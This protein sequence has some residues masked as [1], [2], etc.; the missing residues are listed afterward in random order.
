MFAPGGLPAIAA[1]GLPRGCFGAWATGAAAEAGPTRPPV[2]QASE[3]PQGAPAGPA[4]AEVE[5]E[6]TVDNI[7]DGLWMLEDEIAD[8][9]VVEAGQV[10]D[11]AVAEVVEPS[12]LTQIEHMA[13]PG[14]EG[15]NRW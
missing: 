10:A 5:A 14:K 1:P 15:N 2:A 4:V 7:F 11:G 9:D 12:V 8:Q 3:L 6:L 13:A